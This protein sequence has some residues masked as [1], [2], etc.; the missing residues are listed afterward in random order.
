MIPIGLRVDQWAT[1]DGH[2]GCPAVG[3][4]AS[5]VKKIRLKYKKS[6][7]IF[8]E[9]WRKNRKIEAHFRP[10]SA[11]TSFFFCSTDYE[12]QAQWTCLIW[13]NVKWLRK[14]IR[15]LDGI[16]V[17]W[18]SNQLNWMKLLWNVGTIYGRGWTSWF[19]LCHLAAEKRY[20]RL[21]L[22]KITF[23]HSKIGKWRRFERNG[24]SD[25]DWLHFIRLSTSGRN[26]FRCVSID[27]HQVN[28]MKHINFRITI[29]DIC[30]EKVDWL[31]V[32]I[33][34]LKKTKASISSRTF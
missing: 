8:S 17:E 12:V 16:N 5:P 7:I 24:S 30:Y 31:P 32:D 29:G 18:M 19:Q 23:D 10:C 26:S 13:L 2:Q 28:E 20:F 22:T 14:M 11:R 15:M 33:A 3:P 1:R 9:L 34:T 25:A 21:F 6:E 27:D 4:T